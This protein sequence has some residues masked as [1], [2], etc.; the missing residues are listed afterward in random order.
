MGIIERKNEDS[1]LNGKRMRSSD[2]FVVRVLLLSGTAP[3]GAA[4][5][6]T[7]GKPHGIRTRLFGLI[8]GIVTGNR[9]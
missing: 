1:R 3:D 6:P 4:T 2:L 9:R 5:I 8:R 7:V